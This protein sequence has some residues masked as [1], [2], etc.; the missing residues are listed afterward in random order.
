MSILVAANGVEIK[1]GSRIQFA[2]NSYVGPDVGIVTEINSAN[3]IWATWEADGDA[4][5]PAGSMKFLVIPQINKEII[6]ILHT[7]HGHVQTAYP[8]ALKDEAI[9]QFEAYIESGKIA[10]IK[11]GVL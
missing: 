2:G 11:Y 3:E 8:M 4:H 10:A 5:F 9:K 1:V 6:V 7:E